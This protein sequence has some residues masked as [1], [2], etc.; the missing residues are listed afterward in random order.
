MEDFLEDEVDEPGVESDA[1]INQ[2]CLRERK[3]DGERAEPVVE[4]FVAHY[5]CTLWF[6]RIDNQL[7][8]RDALT[9]GLTISCPVFRLCPGW[10][11]YR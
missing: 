11:A 2:E 10:V 9:R 1:G 7:A 4:I 6:E 3:H 8:S 5:V